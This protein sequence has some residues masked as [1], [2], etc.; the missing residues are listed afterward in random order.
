MDRTELIQF[1]INRLDSV[2]CD[3]CAHNDNSDGC[4]AGICPIR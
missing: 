2:Y 1:V 4:D 3:D